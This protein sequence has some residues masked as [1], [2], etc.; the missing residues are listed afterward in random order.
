[1]TATSYLLRT[2]IF[3]LA[4]ALLVL[5][6]NVVVDPYGITGV[7]RIPHLSEYKVEINEHTGLMKKYQPLFENYNALIVGNSRVEMGMNP[8][9]S[10][11]QHE[12]MKVYNL[13][14][15]G[16]D[17][18]MQLAYALNLIYQKPIQ[19]VFLSI[20]F[21]DFI[22]PEWRP[23]PII[24]MLE[25]EE[26]MFMY[27]TSGDINPD[28]PRIRFLDYY[29][30]LFSLDAMVASISTISGQSEASPDRDLAG[31]NPAR[32][33]TEA[34]RLAGPSE[35]FDQK[36][37]ELKVK[38]SNIWYFRRADQRLDS[39]VE[40][41]SAFL[42]ILVRR[43]IKVYLFTNPFHESYWEMFRAQGYMPLYD[44]WMASIEAVVRKH[45]TGSVLFWN[46]SEDSPF[47]HEK[48]PAKGVKSGPLQWFWEPSHYRRQLGD[49]M[50]DTM[51]SESCETDVAFGRRVH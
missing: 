8:S 49:L 39:V 38:Y 48:V 41:L 30:S 11:F 51:L 44:D 36:M 47:I 35:L 31:F 45:T 14:I 3:A 27:S 13:G 23:L 12:K 5:G 17:L 24:P 18:R 42:D 33:F 20:D 15:P 46:F 22:G 26:E 29:K 2:F 32:D 28:Y 7:K 43:D 4:L 10:C 19:T 16:E 21:A 34:V 1:M 50:I 37:F 40:D 25:Q 6:L 9:H